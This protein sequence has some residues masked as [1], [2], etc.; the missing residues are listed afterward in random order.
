MQRRGV[1]SFLTLGSLAVAVG[2]AMAAAPEPVDSHWLEAGS[3][4]GIDHGLWDVW[5]A[6]YTV[7]GPN[8]ITRVRYGEVSAEDRAALAAYL[9]EMAAVEITA[10]GRDEQFAFWVNLY[11]ALTVDL[12]VRE[13]PV[14]SIRDITSGLFSF[15]P[16]GM[17]I[18]E[19]EGRA[20]SL[21]DIEHG[22]L[23][24]IWHDPRIHYAVNCASLGCP[25]LARAAYRP[26]EIDRMLEEAARAYVNHPR[27]AGFDDRG[28]L[29]VSSI[30]DWFEED[31]GGSE[32]GVIA[33]LTR[34]ADDPLKARLAS[35]SEIYADR[36]DWALNDA[37]VR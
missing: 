22:I 37:T 7:A 6:R 35:V 31:F 23:R 5:L 9:D 21:D 34:Y 15:G 3:R 27:G 1:L 25:N 2:R 12:I 30:Y 14:D 8:G 28:R 36:Y 10:F 16:W 26:A 32:A 4:A 13:Y 11:N 20:L 29:I 19:V 33:H 18:V 17:E 24:A